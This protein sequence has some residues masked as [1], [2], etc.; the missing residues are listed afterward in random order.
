MPEGRAF[1]HAA[2][3][4]CIV[5]SRRA[6]LLTR[7]GEREVAVIG[8]PVRHRLGRRGVEHCTMDVADQAVLY[9]D[10]MREVVA[11]AI[12]ARLTYKDHGHHD[13]LLLHIHNG[14]AARGNLRQAEVARRTAVTTTVEA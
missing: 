1:A 9:A 13:D 6:C 14:G 10:R 8:R 7:E 4:R 5:R 11:P 12:V 2:L 3:P